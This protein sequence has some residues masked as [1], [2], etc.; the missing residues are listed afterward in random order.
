MEL[1]T[2][3]CVKPIVRPAEKLTIAHD[4][5]NEVLT[6]IYPIKPYQ[7]Y[8]TVIFLL[9]NK[10]IKSLLGNILKEY[11]Q[12]MYIIDE[13][14]NI[15]TSLK[16]ENT[17]SQVEFNDII[18]NI[19]LNNK[20]II[21]TKNNN[22]LVSYI[23]SDTTLWTYI[24]I[25]KNDEI[26]RKVND[27]RV[28]L[29][30]T[31]FIIFIIGGIIIFLATYMNYTPIYRLQ[32]KVS[33]KVAAHTK[34]NDEIE[35]LNSA[36]DEII[37]Y[38]YEL[39][40]KIDKHK[41]LIK[42]YVLSEILKGRLDKVNAVL[43]TEH[44]FDL[45]TGD[46]Y[47]YIT[48]IIKLFNLQDESDRYK[49]SQV[50]SNIL[51]TDKESKMKIYHIDYLEENKIFFIFSICENMKEKIRE[52]LR[53]IQ[54]EVCKKC[55]IHSVFGVGT[56][57][58]E[59][60]LIGQSFLEA[61]KVIQSQIIQKADQIVFYSELALDNSQGTG[62]VYPHD[63]LKK[64][65]F[66]IHRGSINEV[67]KTIQ[68]LLD[69]LLIENI[70]P[71]FKRCII[72][73]IFNVLIKI[74]MEKDIKN[75]YMDLMIL[76]DFEIVDELHDLL[77]DMCHKVCNY[78]CEQQSDKNGLMHNMIQ[79]I[80]E[81]YL[82]Y[83]FSLEKMAENFDITVPYLSQFFKDNIGDT[84][85]NYLSDLRLQKVKLL[86]R[87]SNKTIKDIVSEV[88]YIDVSSFS[89]KFK[90]KEGITPGEYRNRYKNEKEE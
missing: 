21:K 86:L 3:L 90:L 61:T 9:D 74:M 79:Y 31:I 24:S 30:Y 82:R 85:T 11:I 41:P 7:P 50:I 35:S 38:N 28:T 17:L 87:G 27:I 25:I 15:I 54:N 23:K 75:N 76:K 60:L 1:R 72:F 53:N 83:D 4:E 36:I 34:S 42:E 64:L 80:N 56:E 43:D 6:Y 69:S 20:E 8:A 45:Q 16:P 12:N 70:P 51:D 49:V 88:G 37:D 67:T 57:Y 22:Y 46:Q 18:T 29:F 81:N 33:E 58:Q 44:D 71:F 68:Q 5:M 32:K 14:N 26:M 73:D 13:N 19:D 89:R 40:E 77:N 2:I 62:Y 10:K 55:N 65:S 59:I 52:V 39:S 66:Q 78:V 63:Q 48:V 47:Y 84:I